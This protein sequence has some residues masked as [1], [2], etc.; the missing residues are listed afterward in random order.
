[1]FVVSHRAHE[2]IVKR[3]GTS[4]TFVTDGLDS[5]LERARA[6]AGD[7]D[8][9]IGGGADVVRQ[10][11][12]AGVVG[13]IRLHLVPILLGDGVRLFD[14][15]HLSPAE[16]TVTSVDPPTASSTCATAPALSSRSATGWAPG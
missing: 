4:Y 8:L 10:C 15:G 2:P 5:A 7:K 13:E 14:Q 9:A 16:L 6:A 12:A 3:G 1:V 11:L